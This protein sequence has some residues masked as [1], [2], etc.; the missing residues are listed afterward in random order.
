MKERKQN[1]YSNHCYK[2]HSLGSGWRVMGRMEVRSELSQ[3][4]SGGL[5]GKVTFVEDLKTE[6]EAAL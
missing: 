1:S 2:V 5:S 6:R 4:R 3:V